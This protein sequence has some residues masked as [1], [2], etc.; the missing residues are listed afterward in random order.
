MWPRGEVGA[1]VLILSLGYG[2]GG[3][4]IVVAALSLA[5]NLVLTGAFIAIVKK[6]FGTPVVARPSARVGG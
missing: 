3:P 4:L 1:G 6:L 2:I 5:L